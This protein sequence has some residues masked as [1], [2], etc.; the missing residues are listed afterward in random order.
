[1]DSFIIFNLFGIIVQI[2]LVV[3]QLGDVKIQLKRIADS[4]EKQ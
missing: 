2:M 3:L 4:L 1:M